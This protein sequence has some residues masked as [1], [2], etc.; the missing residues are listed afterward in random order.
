MIY[1]IIFK[2]K[3]YLYIHFRGKYLAQALCYEMIKEP[4]CYFEHLLRWKNRWEFSLLQLHLLHVFFILQ[5]YAN[6]SISAMYLAPYLELKC[7][8]LTPSFQ[9]CFNCCMSSVESS[10][11]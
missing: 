3:L 9:F 11:E 8:C 1:I 10:D 7:Y 5:L 2:M 4:F 6:M